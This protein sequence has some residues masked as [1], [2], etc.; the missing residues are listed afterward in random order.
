MILILTGIDKNGYETVSGPF[1][2]GRKNI[3]DDIGHAI[4]H[5]ARKKKTKVIIKTMPEKEFYA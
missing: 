4:L 3:E 2:M 1:H 5:F